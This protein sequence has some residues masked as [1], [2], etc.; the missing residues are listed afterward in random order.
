MYTNDVRILAEME[1]LA[2]GFL[3]GGV[4]HIPTLQVF[5]EWSRQESWIRRKRSGFP[6]EEEEAS[7]GA[8]FKLCENICRLTG[9]F[10]QI[11]D[12]NNLS[13]FG[14]SLAVLGPTQCCNAQ[15][16]PVEFPRDRLAGWLASTG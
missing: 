13:H 7:S 15:Q 4:L 10:K 8:R 12:L 5:L 2:G 16:S 14:V 1:E 6:S 9:F 3:V 11:L